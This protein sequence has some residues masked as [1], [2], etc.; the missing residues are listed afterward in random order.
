ME[1]TQQFSFTRVRF[2]L[3][4]LYMRRHSTAKR[5]ITGREKEA[6]VGIKVEG[7]RLADTV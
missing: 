2:I 7:A 4:E 5:A 1:A 3:R 6:V